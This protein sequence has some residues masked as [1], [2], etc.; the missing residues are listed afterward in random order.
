M[1]LIVKT[2][3]NC[4]CKNLLISREIAAIIL[5]EYTKASCQDILLAVCDLVYKQ[6]YIKKVL[7]TNAAY[8][9]LHYVLLFLRR[10]L[11]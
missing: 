7:V 4:C 9:L 5:N 10:D 6:L 8:M 2:R 11:G 3:A 1:R